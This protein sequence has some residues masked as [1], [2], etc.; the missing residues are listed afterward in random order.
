M[1]FTLQPR[2]TKYVYN[3]VGREDSAED[4]TTLTKALRSEMQFLDTKY[5]IQNTNIKHK[6]KM[7]IQQIL[8]EDLIILMKLLLSGVS[9]LIRGATSITGETNLFP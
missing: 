5:K 7:Q 2:N 4:S 8:G 1:Y 6:Y 3:V 9:F